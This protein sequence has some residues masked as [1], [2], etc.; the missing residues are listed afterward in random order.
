M[1]L[2]SVIIT[3]FNSEKFIEQAIDSVYVQTFQDL[4]ILVIDDGLNDGTIY[5]SPLVKDFLS[6]RSAHC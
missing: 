4:D 3:A 1:C 5:C 6:W 2:V